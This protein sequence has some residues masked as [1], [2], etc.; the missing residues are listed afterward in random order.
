LSARRA[1]F[2]K[3]YLPVATAIGADGV[4]QKPFGRGKHC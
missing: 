1:R 4:L 2:Q 3:D